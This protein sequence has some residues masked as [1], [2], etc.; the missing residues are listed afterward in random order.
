MAEPSLRERVAKLEAE[1]QG[2]KLRLT[3]EK[4]GNPWLEVVWGSFADAPAAHAEATRLGREWRE[5]FRPKTRRRR[6]K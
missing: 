5:S 4:A 6:K 1:L 3:A 2:L